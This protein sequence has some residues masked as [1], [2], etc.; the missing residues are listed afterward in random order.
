MKK[1]GG[2]ARLL[3]QLNTR[4]WLSAAIDRYYDRARPERWVHADPTIHPSSLGSPCALEFELGL[5]GH[6][7]KA[8]G[9]GVR[10]MDNGTYVGKR[11]VET[12]TK[13]GILVSYEVPAKDTNPLISGSID[14][15]VMN[16]QN[17]EKSVGEIKSMNSNGFRTLPTISQDRKVNMRALW[18][19][20]RNY[21]LQLTTY[22]VIHKM[23]AWFLFENKDNQEYK[24][25][26]VEPSDEMRAEV[27]D[28]SK[29]PS[30][31]QQ[32]FMDGRLVAPPFERK[33]GTCQ[34]CYR[35]KVCFRLQDGDEE[36]WR[37]VQSQFRQASLEMKDP[38][39]TG[40][41]VSGP[42][43]LSTEPFSS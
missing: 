35:N 30:Q 40:W 39:E 21:C 7:T 43:R 28:A 11:W 19:K 2:V 8:D 24:V 15:I 33:S 13:M 14:V 36:T 1:G 34:R 23:P 9:Q 17:G 5:L 16:P 25:F 12:F 41:P 37:L 10:R 38:Q 18:P 42:R 27:W 26:W 3:S 4:D 20:W 32:A 31:A 22:M 6:R 29:P